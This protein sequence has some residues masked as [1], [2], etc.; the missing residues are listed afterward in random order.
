MQ[1]VD[2]LLGPGE[3]VVLHQVWTVHER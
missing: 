3:G 1:T 2:M